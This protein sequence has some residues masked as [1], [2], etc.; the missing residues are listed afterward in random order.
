M[1]R[2]N[3]EEFAKGNCESVDLLSEYIE[4]LEKYCDELERA[5]KESTKVFKEFREREIRSISLPFYFA[6]KDRE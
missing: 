1:E 2:P 6:D 5:K 4:L 3:Y